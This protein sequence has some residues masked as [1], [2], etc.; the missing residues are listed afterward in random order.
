MD[1]KSTAIVIFLG[2]D[3]SDIVNGSTI[4]VSEI[5]MEWFVGTENQEVTFQ[6]LNAAYPP[7]N[8]PS[9]FPLLSHPMNIS[10]SMK[11]KMA[12]IMFLLLIQVF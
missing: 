9:T 5:T 6:L 7:Y 4:N 8:Q 3:E 10:I 12:K 11:V 2:I 1:D